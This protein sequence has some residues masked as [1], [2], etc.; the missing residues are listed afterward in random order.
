MTV[1]ELIRELQNFDGDHIVTLTV[2]SE[3]GHDRC[4]ITEL[5]YDRGAC[6]IHADDM[7]GG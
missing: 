5:V 7:T 1:K 3:C 6:E 2:D 4:N